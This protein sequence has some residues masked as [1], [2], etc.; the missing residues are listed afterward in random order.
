MKMLVPLLKNYEEFPDSH[1]TAL[2]Q[3]QTSSG[4]LHRSHTPVWCSGL[5]FG[6]IGVSF[7]APWLSS[8]VPVRAFDTSLTCDS[9]RSI[10]TGTA[11]SLGFSFLFWSC[12]GRAECIWLVFHP[13]RLGSRCGF[14]G[15][16]W[17]GSRWD[18]K[19]GCWSYPST[20]WAATLWVSPRGE[21]AEAWSTGSRVT[22]VRDPFAP[23][24][25]PASQVRRPH[26]S[27]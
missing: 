1:S 11:Q 20:G 13:V 10:Q 21:E 5:H 3:A 6:K 23:R 4:P 8:P 18:L 2:K 9:E 7:R 12:W 14:S 22:G 19:E 24:R 25:R 15:I 17:T 16:S 26:V 27:I